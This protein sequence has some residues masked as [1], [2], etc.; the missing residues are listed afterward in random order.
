MPIEGA[1][2]SSWH[3]GAGEPDG[4]VL[5]PGIGVVQQL[6]RLDQTPLPVPVPQRDPQWCQDHV[7]DFGGGGMPAHG[8]LGEHVDDEGDVDEPAQVLQ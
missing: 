3:R 6:T 4:C 1:M 8:P 7:G 5:A 2:P